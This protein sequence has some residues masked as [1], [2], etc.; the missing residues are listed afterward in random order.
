MA[1]RRLILRR[2]EIVRPPNKMHQEIVSAINIDVFHK[3]APAHIKIMNARRNAKGGIMG[4]TQQHATPETAKR[5]RD[6]II[7]AAKTL[8]TGVVDVEEHET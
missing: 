7:T 2:D 1:D 5:Y 3:Q 4:I 6:I 8:N